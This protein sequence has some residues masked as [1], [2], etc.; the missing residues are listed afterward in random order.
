[1]PLHISLAALPSSSFQAS[2]LHCY[3]SPRDLSSSLRYLISD[4][5]NFFLWSR[6]DSLFP[7]RYDNLVRTCLFT[8]PPPKSPP[9]FAPAFRVRN[10]PDFNCLT[11]YPSDV[12]LASST[13]RIATLCDRHSC[14]LA[15]AWQAIRF[16][17][18]HCTATVVI[19]A[20]S[21]PVT[22][23][24][25]Y[26]PRYLHRRQIHNSFRPPCLY[27]LKTSLH[28]EGFLPL[29]RFLAV[30]LPF[31]RILLRFAR[32]T[33]D[34]RYS[35]HITQSL[36]TLTSSREPLANM[37]FN[38]QGRACFTCK[39]FQNLSKICLFNLVRCQPIVGL[40]LPA[41]STRRSVC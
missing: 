24:F 17:S 8:Y 3:S 9:R 36:I 22:T 23:T 38:T 26:S 15:W 37:D 7:Q 25:T 31:S 2:L 20:R 1:V 29:T 32:T 40:A 12:C 5:P 13:E 14:L 28:F 19:P 10:T 35:L 34:L 11:H 33:A 18:P 39:W 27:R 4:D 41:S 6:L 30:A 21:A 16:T